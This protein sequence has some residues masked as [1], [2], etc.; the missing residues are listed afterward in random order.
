MFKF[1]EFH[2]TF[3]KKIKLDKKF[4]FYENLKTVTITK[5]Q[6]KIIKKIL[7]LKKVI[8]DFCND[9]IH[10]DKADTYIPLFEAFY[11]YFESLVENLEKYGEI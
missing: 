4:Y 8:M 2:L 9:T 7:G 10:N 3:S 6:I 11:E 5:N 1:D